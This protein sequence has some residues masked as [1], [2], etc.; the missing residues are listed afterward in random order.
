M[1]KEEF[2]D[3]LSI[4]LSSLSENEVEERL[5][6]YSEMIDDRIEDGLSEEDAVFEMGNVEEIVSRIIS[7]T[8]LRKIVKEKIKPKRNLKI[9]E[10]VLLILGAPLWFPLLFAAFAVV[11]AI[12]V[13]LW[14]V[15][16]SL[17]SV[18]FS[19]AACGIAGVVAGIYFSFRNSCLTGLA[20]IGASVF[21]LGMSVF[22]FFGCK[23]ITQIFI[24]L[25]KNFLL[26]LKKSI[27]GKG[28]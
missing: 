15:I 12:Y 27:I 5:M 23:K 7:E 11:L 13:S 1:N 28:K 25:T 2:L 17:W 3:A 22:A 9:L 21:G 18:F 26:Y 10:I 16:I 8:P 14:S 6:F 20:V 24:Y 19:L 4:G